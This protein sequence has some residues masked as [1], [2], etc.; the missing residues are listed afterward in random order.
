MTITCLP[1]KGRIACDNGETFDRLNTFGLSMR[2]RNGTIIGIP[3]TG[4]TDACKAN[5][6]N[7]TCFSTGYD[8]ACSQSIDN[9]KDGKTGTSLKISGFDHVPKPPCAR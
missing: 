7:I 4:E 6:D 1:R 8:T 5:K 2:T 9:R 3:D